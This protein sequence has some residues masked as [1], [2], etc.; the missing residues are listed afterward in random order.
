MS[1]MWK[2]LNNFD[3]FIHRVL[4]AVCALFLA[5]MVG[6]TLY[7]VIMR[8]VFE[9]PPVWGDLLTVLSNI[10]L[11]FIA[12][13]LTARDNEHIALNLIY[14]KLPSWLALYIRQFWKLMIILIGLV[15]IVYGFELVEGMRG[16]YWE[17]WYFE[18]TA[19]GIEFKENYMPKKYAVMILPLAGF[20]TTFGAAICFFKKV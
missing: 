7:N 8:Y 3:R 14:E 1:A 15:M 9:N 10:W 16:K 12:L 13:S 5:L 2:L 19:Q 18:F 4:E 6:F 11:M 20:L 17:M